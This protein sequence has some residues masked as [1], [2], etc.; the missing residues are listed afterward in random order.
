M[1]ASTH[2]QSSVFAE[3]VYVHDPSPRAIND[4]V[5]NSLYAG[6][7]E[8]W[9]PSQC[10]TPAAEDLCQQKAELGERVSESTKAV[11]RKPRVSKAQS[12]GA[13]E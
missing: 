8:V 2:S 1:I 3:A 10:F 6:F 11:F 13:M 12:W 5:S 4:T 7:M 9:H